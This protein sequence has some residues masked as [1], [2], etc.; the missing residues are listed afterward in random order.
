MRF[1]LGRC[2]F[3]VVCWGL[4]GGWSVFYKVEEGVYE[5]FIECLDGECE[6]GFFV[7]K[8]WAL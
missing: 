8:I 5:Y 7:G 6:N 1:R 3:T 4:R 2:W